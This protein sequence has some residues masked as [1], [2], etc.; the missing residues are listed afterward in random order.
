MYK[1]LDRR[2]EAACM[3]RMLDTL[4]GVWP[5]LPKV[6]VSG[7]FDEPTL[8]A[9]M[10]FQREFCPPVTGR[11]DART[12]RT[13]ERMYRQV[14][15]DRAQAVFHAGMPAGLTEIRPGEDAQW[16][17]QLKFMFRRLADVLEGIEDDAE[18]GFHGEPSANNVRWLQQAAQME[19]DG[20]VC[21][22]VWELLARLYDICVVRAP[23][24]RSSEE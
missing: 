3:Q 22:Q 16:L 24:I 13:M 5:S 8:E 4:A 7:E 18:D 2:R 10:I 23:E 12:W 14:E 19:P 6:E 17:A 21:P 20:I 11:P 1:E 15:H 9:L